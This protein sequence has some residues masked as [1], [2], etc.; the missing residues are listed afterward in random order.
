M[1]WDAALAQLDAE[2][3][4]HAGRFRELCEDDSDLPRRDGYRDVVV[5]LASGIP[6]APPPAVPVDYAAGPAP[7]ACC[8]G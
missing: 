2:G 7:R 4:L 5:R 6:L 8:G 3:H 1:T